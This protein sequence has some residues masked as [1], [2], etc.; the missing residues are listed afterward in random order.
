MHL[1]QRPHRKRLSSSSPVASALT[2]SVCTH[3]SEHPRATC[4]SRYRCT[5]SLASLCAW[6][7]AACFA[8]CVCCAVKRGDA[9]LTT[10]VGSMS[11][12]A[13]VSTRAVQVAN[14][15]RATRRCRKSG[16]RSACCAWMVGSSSI[17]ADGSSAC[18]QDSIFFCACMTTAT[19]QHAATLQG[20]T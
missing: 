7:A 17:A 13:G 18:S 9:A 3:F 20:I 10:G 2:R 16:R 15:A 5:A 8:A 12:R 4:H 14:G 1:T 6:L 19:P 11:E